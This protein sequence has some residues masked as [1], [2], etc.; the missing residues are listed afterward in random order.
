MGRISR[1]IETTN[2]M[3]P[4][5]PMVNMKITV[6]SDMEPCTLVKVRLP[7]EDCS[8]HVEG[9]KVFYCYDGCSGLYQNFLIFLPEYTA[10]Q[11][12]N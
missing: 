3:E 1:H 4:Q 8:I 5:I 10:L 11:P 7:G 6:L 12:R 9:D 2:I